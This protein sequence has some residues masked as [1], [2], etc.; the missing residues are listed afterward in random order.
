MNV[1]ELLERTE[2]MERGKLSKDIS[3]KTSRTHPGNRPTPPR[4]M[5]MRMIRGRKEGGKCHAWN[6]DQS[7]L[8]FAKQQ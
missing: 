3:I 5:K 2:E 6:R 8:E 7:A 4:F 1:L